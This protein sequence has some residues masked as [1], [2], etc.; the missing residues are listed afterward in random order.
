MDGRYELHFIYRNVC[1]KCHTN[2]QY[3]IIFC[4]ICYYINTGSWVDK[5]V[6]NLR[7]YSI[8]M[9]YYIGMVQRIKLNQWDNC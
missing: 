7:I 8:R 9:Q 4:T 2:V 1:T 6:I 3:A 5:E